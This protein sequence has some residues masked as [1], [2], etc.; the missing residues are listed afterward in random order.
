MGG[1]E[2]GLGEEG[3]QGKRLGRAWEGW[4]GKGERNESIPSNSFCSR[5]FH[6]T[7]TTGA[8]E[9]PEHFSRPATSIIKKLL[10]RRPT[11]R[12]GVV[13]GGAMLI[14]N[15]MWFNSFFASQ[16]ADGTHSL[17]HARTHALTPSLPPSHPLTR[18]LT[19]QARAG[20]T[21]C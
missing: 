2:G 7:H 13:K 12:L 21:G 8:I 9:W 14:K 11:R 20:G 3:D 6:D 10:Y 1:K 18:S 16:D 15:H 4:E 19:P 5:C 17:T